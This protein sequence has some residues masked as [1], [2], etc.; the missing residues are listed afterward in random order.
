MCHE[1]LY[2]FIARFRLSF[3]G[4]GDS[5]KGL[6]LR[7]CGHVCFTGWWSLLTNTRH[8][9]SYPHSPVQ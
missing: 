6:H 9:L 2:L 8:Y 3:V 5:V 1:G 4:D 7:W